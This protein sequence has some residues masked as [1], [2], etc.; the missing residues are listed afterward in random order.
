[1]KLYIVDFEFFNDVNFEV[2]VF[3]QK[4][5]FRKKPLTTKLVFYLGNKMQKEFPDFDL[6]MRI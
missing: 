5:G 4:K 2:K 1:L 3:G 6:P